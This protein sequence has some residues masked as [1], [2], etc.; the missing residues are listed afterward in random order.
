M[1]DLL[2]QG[3]S[4]SRG[5]HTAHTT[6]HTHN[7]IQALQSIRWHSALL[8]QACRAAHRA[9]T[10]GQLDIDGQAAGEGAL[11]VGAPQVGQW[12]PAVCAGGGHADSCD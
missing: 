11:P 8:P 12:G 4:A 9:A 1:E 5:W 7:T 6:T 3:H 2:G 10:L